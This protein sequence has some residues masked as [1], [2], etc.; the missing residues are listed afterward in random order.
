M[1]LTPFSVLAFT[2]VDEEAEGREEAP[3]SSR[4]SSL[5]TSSKLM[6]DTRMER[7][8][9]AAAQ[10]RKGQASKDPVKTKRAKERRCTRER[11]IKLCRC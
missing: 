8:V 7:D 9:L 11:E 4:C 1:K 6:T 2:L 5:V 3:N 10:G